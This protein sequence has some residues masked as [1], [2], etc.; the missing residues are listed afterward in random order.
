[1]WHLTEF[2]N[3]EFRTTY[4]PKRQRPVS[5]YLSAQA[6]FRHL[7]PEQVAVIQKEIDAARD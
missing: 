4:T 2:E 3:G 5:E 6:R 1:M 7:N